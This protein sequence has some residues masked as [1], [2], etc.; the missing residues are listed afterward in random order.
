MVMS[1]G[2]IGR[3]NYKTIKL[4]VNLLVGLTQ[5][6][7]DMHLNSYFSSDENKEKDGKKRKMC[8]CL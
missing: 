6:L 1:L 5:F 7:R 3:P 4:K 8:M 2:F